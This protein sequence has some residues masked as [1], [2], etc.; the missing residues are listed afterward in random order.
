MILLQQHRIEHKVYQFY[1]PSYTAILPFNCKKQ[2]NHEKLIN[3]PTKKSKKISLIVH[4]G[5]YTQG[6]PLYTKAQIVIFDI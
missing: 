3:I 6:V 2:N 4:V 1:I 5:T